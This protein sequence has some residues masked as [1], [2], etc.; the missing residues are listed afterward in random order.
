MNNSLKQGLGWKKLKW[1]KYKD[2]PPAWDLCLIHRSPPQHLTE[3]SWI[4]QTGD[5]RQSEALWEINAPRWRRRHKA[6]VKTQSRALI[7]SHSCLLTLVSRAMVTWPVCP[8]GV[9]PQEALARRK[10][11]KEHPFWLLTAPVS[12]TH[13]SI[14]PTNN[15]AGEY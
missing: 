10:H 11:Q 4:S 9:Y 5:W 2:G 14:H 3:D 6:A 7:Q 12:V 1:L 15:V 13:G 8:G